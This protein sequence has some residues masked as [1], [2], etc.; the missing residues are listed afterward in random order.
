LIV[1]SIW[2]LVMTSIAYVIQYFVER[3]YGRGFARTERTG[4]R[5]FAFRYR[6]AEEVP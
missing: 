5:L 3:R 2:Y 1:A 4:S 6:H